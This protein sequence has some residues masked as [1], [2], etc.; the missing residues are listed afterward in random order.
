MKKKMAYAG[1]ATAL[2]FTVF[3]S[4][5]FAAS[6][7]ADVQ[8]SVTEL[9][10]AHDLNVKDSKFKN[11]DVSRFLN[12]KAKTGFSKLATKNDYIMEQE[13]NDIPNLANPLQL[14]TGIAGDFSYNATRDG[15][16]DL[17]EINVPK[18]GYLFLGGGLNRVDYLTRFGFGLFDVYGKIVEP[19]YAASKDGIDYLILPVKSGTYYIAAANLDEYVSY[20]QYLLYANMLDTTAPDAPKVNPIDD[21]DKIIS[22]TAEAGSMVTI[23]NGTVI[24]TTVNVNNSGKFKV[25]LPKPFKAGTKLSFTATDDAGNVSKAKTITVLD[26]TPPATLTV[27]KVTKNSKYVSGKTEA[28]VSVTVK[29]GSKTLARGK[30][31]A[32]GYFKLKIKAQKKNTVLTITATDAAGNSKVVKVK[33][34]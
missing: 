25:N 22:G 24:Y 11:L 23:K 19:E 4:T 13:P 5:T 28:K 20:D 26:K 7:A 34:K 21:N 33:V 27:N 14:G 8:K 17:F 12:D 31:D 6:P 32:K 30:A 9:S 2:L 3:Q 10:K 15:D 18:P 1:I 16:F 29:A